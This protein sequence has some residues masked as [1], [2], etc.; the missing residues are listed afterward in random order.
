MFNIEEL[1]IFA[2]ADNGFTFKLLGRDNK[3]TDAA[4]T[5]SAIY[6]KKG[7][8]CRVKYDAKERELLVKHGLTGKLIEELKQKLEDK[9]P[10]DE[11]QVKAL[12]DYEESLEDAYIKIILVPLTK[13]VEG[14]AVNGE[15]Y[16]I[17]DKSVYELYK[18]YPTVL[19]QAISEI[20]NFENLS[21]N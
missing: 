2:I 18:K 5:L 11:A 9:E 3:E 13:K 14:L 6:G 12:R 15:A 16:P 8:D 10:V 17:N 7:K 4:I 1:D 21:K 20:Y 19:Q